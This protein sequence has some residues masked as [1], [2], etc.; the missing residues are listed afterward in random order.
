MSLYFS[1][2]IRKTPLN[3][4]YNFLKILFSIFSRKKTLLIQNLNFFMF[5]KSPDLKKI[6]ADHSKKF[7]I[8]LILKM[9]AYWFIFF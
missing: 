4:L 5:K 8:P 6:H 9:T 2:V 1:I 3:I 7:F